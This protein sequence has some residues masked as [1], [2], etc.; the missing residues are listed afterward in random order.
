MWECGKDLAQFLASHPVGQT[1]EIKGKS[2]LE[3]SPNFFFFI[4]SLDS[5]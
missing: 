5:Q 1:I 4:S 2:V 3:V